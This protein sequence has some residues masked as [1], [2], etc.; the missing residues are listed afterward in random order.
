M[1]VGSSENKWRGEAFRMGGALL[2]HTSHRV[3]VLW[4][5]NHSVLWIGTHSVQVL[6]LSCTSILTSD[7]MGALLE[8][9][10]WGGACLEAWWFK[11]C[12]LVGGEGR[13]MSIVASSL[14]KRA[15]LTC[16]LPA[17][18]VILHWGP[19]A[20]SQKVSTFL[21]HLNSWDALQ[22]N[23]HLCNFANS[24]LHAWSKSFH[25][26]GKNLNAW[27]KNL[28]AWG[29]SVGQVQR[30]CTMQVYFHAPTFSEG[31]AQ[32]SNAASYMHVIF[33]HR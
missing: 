27:G 10:D 13:P 14:F 18:H 31:H 25:A 20:K 17:L 9:W 12:I 22:T 23:I 7:S 8:L 1:M 15:W 21:D 33:A 16:L 2:E 3:Q 11:G 28:K 19:I 29:K 6:E 26:W 32:N 4:L 30:K 5:R 24:N